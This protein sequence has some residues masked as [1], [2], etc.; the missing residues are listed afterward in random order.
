LVEP[1][2]VLRLHLVPCDDKHVIRQLALV[3]VFEHRERMRTHIRQK[4]ISSPVE[5]LHGR[6]MRLEIPM[7]HQFLNRFSIAHQGT[8][9]PLIP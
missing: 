7:T 1:V 2:G 8:R 5:H 9:L 3:Q 4:R 6:H